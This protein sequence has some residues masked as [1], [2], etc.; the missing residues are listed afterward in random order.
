MSNN[1]KKTPSPRILIVDDS[2]LILTMLTEILKSEGYLVD[3]VKTGFGALENVSQETYNAVILD[4]NLPDLN[5]LAVLKILAE[6]H[7]NLPVI[8]HTGEVSQELKKECLDAG[9][10][11][12]LTKPCNV[13]ELKRLVR[14]AVASGCGNQK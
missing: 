12:F 8:M 13:T 5:G 4:M 6:H 11:A 3:G 1:S 14:E 10:Y 2:L 9:A 7:P